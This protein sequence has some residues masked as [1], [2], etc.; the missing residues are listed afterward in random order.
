MRKEVRGLRRAGGD[1]GTRE[2]V[3]ASDEPDVR[4]AGILGG[5]LGIGVSWFREFVS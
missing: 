4:R 5:E 3:R 2:V 1:I